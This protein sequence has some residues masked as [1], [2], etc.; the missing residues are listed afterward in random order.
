VPVPVSSALLGFSASKGLPALAALAGIPAAAFWSLDTYCLR[1]ERAFRDMY[2]DVAA[3]RVHSFEIKPGPHA[4]RHSWGRT[5]RSL[6]LSAFYGPILV[7]CLL[8]S[9]VTAAD[10]NADHG[11]HPTPRSCERWHGQDRGDCRRR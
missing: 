4:A 3:K 8:V 6:S 10:T 1:Q 7:V 5:G 2:D 11:D 9:V